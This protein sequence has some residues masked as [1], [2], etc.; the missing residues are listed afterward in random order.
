MEERDFGNPANS[1]K[2]RVIYRGYAPRNV[3]FYLKT[4]KGTYLL[5]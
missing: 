3:Y 4:I 5:S 2:G 1:V